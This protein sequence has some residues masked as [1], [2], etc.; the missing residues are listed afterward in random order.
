[1]NTPIDSSIPKNIIR[2]PRFEGGDDSIITMYK[3]HINMPAIAMHILNR[4]S[5]RKRAVKKPI[6][7][8][9]GIINPTP[10]FMSLFI[11]KL[12]FYLRITPKVDLFRC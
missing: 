7:A 3:N 2:L 10:D 1:M 9:N 11:T 5:P 12:R 4:C 6:I 8:P